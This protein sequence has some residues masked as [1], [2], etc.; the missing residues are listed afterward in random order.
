MVTIRFR[1]KSEISPQ[2]IL[3]AATDFTD[4]RPEVW[5]NLDPK[6]YRVIEV[7]E[8]TAEAMEGSPM[9]GGIWARE[10]YDWSTPGLVR[11]EVQESNVFR[12]GSSWELRVV[13][14]GTSGSVVEWTSRRIPKGLRGR[15]L[16]FMLRLV[17]KKALSKSFGRTLASIGQS[18]QHGGVSGS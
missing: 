13:P 17:G 5:P 10:R 2:G 12:P 18:I 7:G 3:A 4:R 15:V 1:A 16:A 11:A 9:L 14:D 8:H 6:V